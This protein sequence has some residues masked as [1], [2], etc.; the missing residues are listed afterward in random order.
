MKTIKTRLIPFKPLIAALALV[1][2]TTAC[3]QRTDDT[4]MAPTDDA[5]TMPPADPVDTMAPPA[6]MQEMDP[7]AGL[8]GTELDEC[9]RRQAEMATPPVIDETQPLPPPEPPMTDDPAPTTP[10]PAN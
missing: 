1:F 10:P 7:C 6:P 9:L 3:Q 5:T 2:A 4:L 8:M